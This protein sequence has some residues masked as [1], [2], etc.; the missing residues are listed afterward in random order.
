MSLGHSESVY[1]ENTRLPY[2]NNKEWIELMDLIEFYLILD[3]TIS[4]VSFSQGE[5]LKINFWFFGYV[6][7]LNEHIQVL[8]FILCEW[9]SDFIK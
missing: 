5:V 9:Y 1:V 3:V 6:S 8:I 7:P 2:R 4:S